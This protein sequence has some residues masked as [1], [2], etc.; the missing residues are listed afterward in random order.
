VALAN[1]DH[2]ID[3]I[4]VSIDLAK[5]CAIIS[6]SVQNGWFEKMAGWS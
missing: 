6:T 3:A 1:T 4:G 5:S 2:A